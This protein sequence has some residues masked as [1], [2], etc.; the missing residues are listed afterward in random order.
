MSEHC[1]FCG[2]RIRPDGMNE[3]ES[4]GATR[5][6]ADE[7]RIHARCPRC[8]ETKLVQYALGTVALQA[9]GRCQGSFLAADEWDAL[10]DAFTNA[11]LP[12]IVIP[13]AP[14]ENQVASFT[15]YRTAP[16]EKVDAAPDLD[17]AVRC[18]TCGDETERFEFAGVT[19]IVVDVCRLHG[20]WLDRGELARV[21]QVLR[22]PDEIDWASRASPAGTSYDRDAV[23]R[24]V[25][26]LRESQREA[27]MSSLEPRYVP[28]TSAKQTGRS[29][30]GIMERFG[31]IVGRL[32]KKRRA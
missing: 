14:A 2:H 4:C 28:R 3:C 18:P 26:S 5:E 30:A 19:G 31:T 10:L 21:V 16:P 22:T 25:R 29:N 20:I 6:T 9:C 1:F 12:P 23:E 32:V 17:E 11:P 15:P 8:H 27:D 7:K 24:R 13:E